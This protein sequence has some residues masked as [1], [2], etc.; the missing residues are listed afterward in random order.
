M[1]VTSIKWQYWAD[2]WTSAS[3]SE[4]NH[5]HAAIGPDNGSS[6]YRT[7]ISIG[8]SALNASKKRNKLNF[9]LE[10]NPSQSYGNEESW[11]N[12][13]ACCTDTGPTKSEYGIKGTVIKEVTTYMDFDTSDFYVEFSIDISKLNKNAQT[14]YVYLTSQSTSTGNYHIFK[15]REDNTITELVAD[16]ITSV[17][18]KDITTAGGKIYK[19]SDTVSFEWSKGSDGTNNALGGYTAYLRYGSAPTTSAYDK[20]TTV[21]SSTLKASFSISGATRGK[22]VFV[23]VRANGTNTSYNGSIKTKELGVINSL[24][25]AP[26]FS[27]NGTALD[28]LN[29]ITYT[30][31]AG[32]DTNTGQTISLAYSLNGG[33]KT[34]C[35]SPLTITTATSG[36]VSGSNSIVFYTHD[37]LEYSSASGSHTFT[38]TFKPEIGT[39]TT[40]F[41]AVKD[42]EGKTS[43]GLVKDAKIVFTMSSGTPVTAKLY[44]RTSSGSSGLSGEGE[45]ISSNFYSYNKDTKTITIPSIVNISN[46][47]VG[48]YF[49]FGFL[50]NDG[51]INSD[52]K[53]T[54][55]VKRKPKMPLLSEIVSYDRYNINTYEAIGKDGYYK[56]KISVTYKNQSAVDGC[57]KLS[58]VSIIAYYDNTSKDYTC[59]TEVGAQK[60]ITLDL[61]QVNANT[62]TVFKI[63]VVDE[64]GQSQISSSSFSL[65][66]SSQLEFGGEEVK[67]DNNNLKPMTNTKDFQI[68]H[69]IAQ[70]SGTS[71]VAYI[72]TIKVGNNIGTISNYTTQTTN[73]QIIITISASVIN[74]LVRTL[75]EDEN[76]A[77]D[78][79]ITVMAADVFD[80]TAKRESAIFKVNFT[81]PPVFIAADPQFNIRHDYYIS[82]SVATVNMGVAINTPLTSNP[83]LV[84]SGEGIVFVLPK[85]S[86]PNN[87]IDFYRIYL[88]R[89][90][91]EGRN[92]IYDVNQVNYSQ[93][94][95]DIPYDTLLNGAKDS[96]SDGN[97]YYRYKTSRYSKN[98]YFYFKLQV[99]DKTGNTSRELICPYGFV[100]CRTV[101]PLFS[102]GNI[103]VDRNGT[104]VTLNYDFKITDLGGSATKNGWT[105]GFYD[106]YPNFERS[107]N[108]YSPKASLVI[109]IAP[110]QDFKKEET[111]SNASNPE[112]FTPSSN[113]KLYEFTHKQ[114]RLSGFAESYAKIFMRF[115]LTVSYGLYDNSTNATISSVPQ[116]YTYFGKVP[117]VAHR[118]HKVGINT[119]SLGQDDVMVVEN[120]QGTRYVRF[121]GTNTS[122]ASKTYEITF[123]LLNGAITGAV[124]DC[125][126]W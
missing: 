11:D 7:C 118:A 58:S 126:S 72:Y 101:E 112:V 9:K 29:N 84:N 93:K 92:N 64:A 120:Y 66:R 75:A 68:A 46:I 71:K 36:V 109:E 40:T 18:T 96:S 85:A 48:N 4:P 3:D 5:V 103:R 45:E 82:N 38:A 34:T 55:Q 41:T 97:F 22:S 32:S 67:L 114:T 49:E 26:S 15:F 14:V 43:T 100:G 24:P 23:G 90:D 99:V 117:T 27:S 111:I 94:L 39:P 10:L 63:K 116:V 88:A 20:T 47:A 104:N 110:N 121:K 19:T 125:G 95:I 31:T 37:G 124:I 28:T 25:N 106:S 16:D 123:D 105:Y 13:T 17:V 69:P 70:A 1:S 80:V 57:A 122:D 12:L 98:E 87:D 86:D 54:G 30:I 89:N 44:V 50:V 33:A 21:N 2:G 91:F 35:T 42:M 52:K 76:S 83:H 119:T 53:W 115:T 79:Q 113:Q 107:I 102:A 56:D 6:H 81:E 61:N 51:T 65:I 60:S 8:L 77:F 108:G 78:S 62:S 74:T 59:S 73:D